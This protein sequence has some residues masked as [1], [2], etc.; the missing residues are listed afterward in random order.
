MEH[1]GETTNLSRDIICFNV[2]PMFDS[3][4]R[5]HLAQRQR[6]HQTCC[7]SPRRKSWRRVPGSH[8]R[9]SAD[10]PPFS[11][12]LRCVFLGSIYRTTFTLDSPQRRRKNRCMM[13]AEEWL[14]LVNAVYYVYQ[15]NT[16]RIV[17]E[18]VEV[19][20]LQRP[21]G[22]HILITGTSLQDTIHGIFRTSLEQATASS[23]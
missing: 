1:C 15:H 9:L 14:V 10:L 4:P 18:K 12:H 7:G 19:V 6:C 16:P 11:R 5:I 22:L 17:L 2:Q 23:T 13:Y 20:L 3:D 21:I 8:P